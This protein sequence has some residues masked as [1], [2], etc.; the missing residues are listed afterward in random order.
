MLVGYLAMIAH[1]SYTPAFIHIIGRITALENIAVHAQLEEIE[2]SS[3]ENVCGF[4]FGEMGGKYKRLQLVEKHSLEIL[5]V[6]GTD[7]KHQ[8]K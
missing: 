6:L 1:A 3:C 8:C 4:I 7:T 2:M 5:F